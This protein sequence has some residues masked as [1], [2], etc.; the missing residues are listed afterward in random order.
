MMVEMINMIILVILIMMM[1]KMTNKHRDNM[2]RVY[3]PPFWKTLENYFFL[4]MSSYPIEENPRDIIEGRVE[5]VCLYTKSMEEL[6]TLE[7]REGC[8]FL[9]PKIFSLWIISIT[10]LAPPP[11]SIASLR[12]TPHLGWHKK[13]EMCG[14]LPNI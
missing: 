8:N 11:P 10:P 1:M 9:S 4:R 5:A 14:L 7:I 13:V 3:L 6:T 2:T 12:L